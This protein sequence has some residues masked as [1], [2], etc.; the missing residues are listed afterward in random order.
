MLE[1]PTIEANEQIDAIQASSAITGIM[2][3]SDAS[4]SI[5]HRRVTL[6]GTNRCRTVSVLA[7]LSTA[8]NPSI[9]D[10][11]TGIPLPQKRTKSEEA[12][13]CVFSCFSWRPFLRAQAAFGRRRSDIAVSRVDP[14]SLNRAIPSGQNVQ[15]DRVAANQPFIQVLDGSA[16]PVQRFVQVSR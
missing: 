15:A 7:N 9:R 14:T 13:S 11:F 12:L 3:Q 10:G 4:A 5:G 1:I 6:A 8:Q 2:S 16:T